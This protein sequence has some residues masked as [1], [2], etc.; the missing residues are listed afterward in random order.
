MHRERIDARSDETRSGS[1]RR[2]KAVPEG[3]PPE[4]R[5]YGEQMPVYLVFGGLIGVFLICLVGALVT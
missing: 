3:P 5:V 4:T 2:A 1:A